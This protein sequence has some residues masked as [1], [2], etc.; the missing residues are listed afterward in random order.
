[1]TYKALAA[2]LILGVCFGEM[3]SASAANAAAATYY[4]YAVLMDSTNLRKQIEALSKTLS[5]AS[6]TFSKD[7]TT[8]TY[9]S[10][11]PTTKATTTYSYHKQTVGS[12]TYWVRDGFTMKVEEGY[13]WEGT[14]SS[15]A[16]VTPSSNTKIVVIA[17]A[18]ATDAQKA[19]I[20]YSTQLASADNGITTLNSDHLF[21]A[22]ETNF[23][24]STNAGIHARSDWD[25]IIYEGNSVVNAGKTNYSTY[26]KTAT[27]VS[28]MPSSPTAGTLYYDQSDGL[29]KYYSTDGEL[30]S[31]NPRKLYSILNASTQTA[32]TGIFV[33]NGGKEI[34]QG[35]V[36][37][38]NNEI[39]LTSTDSS[40][41]IYSY[42][43]GD[44]YD[45]TLP[46]SMSSMTVADFNEAVSILENNIEKVHKDNIAHLNFSTATASS[47]G[48]S[49]GVISLTTNGGADVPGT[50]SIANS[51]GTGGSGDDLKI[52]ISGSTSDGTTSSFSVNAG[53]LVAAN[54]AS[55]TTTSPDKLTSLSIN[56]TKYEIQDRAVAS[57]T[58]SYDASG[59]GNGT[60]TLALND[61][62]TAR[63]TGLKN[64]YVASGSVSYDA[65]G[66]GTGKITLTQNDGST[67]TIE[68]LKDTYTKSASYDSGSSSLVFTRNDGSTYS[69]SGIAST[70][71]VAAAKTEVKAGSDL[72]KVTPS[73]DK[74][75]N[76][77]VYT[78]D[79]KDMHVKEGSAS[80]T[81]N[82]AGTL[83][84]THQDGTT[85]TVT[86]LKDTYVTSGTASYDNKGSGT[87]TLTMND[88][89]KADVTGLKNTYV[90]SGTAS[91]D[92]KGSGTATLTMNDGT[93][94]SV[95]GLKDTQSRVAA[96]QNVVVT[97]S[98]NEIGTKD[99]TVSLDAAAA[100]AVVNANTYL[101]ENG[102]NAQGLR[103]TNVA[104]GEL[105]ATSTDAV[106]G[107]QLFATNQAV[108]VNSNSITQLNR[109][110]QELDR[111]VK[112]AGANAAALA[113]LHPL[114]YDEDHLVT[115]SAGV[116][117]YHGAAATAFGFFVRPT[118]NLL[119]SLGGSIA[120][121]NDVMGN[122]GVSYRFGDNSTA[123]YKTKLNVAERVS[124]LT[125]ENR[126]LQAKLQSS[127]MRLEAAD[128]EVKA[129][130]AGYESLKAELNKIKAH[131]N[132]R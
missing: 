98:G 125:N 126:D 111:K 70:V 72:V 57:G 62:S 90:A 55:A 23:A 5:N 94:A 97:S 10:T 52:V 35:N 124:T 38:Q 69:V 91:Y 9:A 107:S 49:S 132:L 33:I 31:V 73:A 75:D 17:D 4:Q 77:T 122:L 66:N 131:L 43:G 60:A 28:S 12:S 8:L 30:S 120:S 128:K 68:G 36:Y 16:A 29:Y 84:L 51:G 20:L 19:G 22:S 116:G 44:L 115:V 18:D 130:R 81:S 118:P 117:G 46:V 71:A 86:G 6:Y 112:K 101:S 99:Y 82:G 92:D 63:V 102:I 89:S 127:N 42:W 93:T 110:T 48:V 37:G 11:D 1:M 119:F 74:T 50:I 14:N 79:V 39:L 32:E 83:T 96:G 113:A 88:G 3:P 105:S 21:S 67:V 104:P 80:Y 34:Y 54:P 100:R 65:S 103:I 7:E 56:G 26:F 59:N 2:A 45:E 40:G 114:E 61:G 25:M 108:E 24:A 87:A 106:N 13:R 58:V 121:G 123:R 15:G 78:V 95:T 64:T 47:S 85:A 41:T 109:V 27:T 129:L 76:H 53:S